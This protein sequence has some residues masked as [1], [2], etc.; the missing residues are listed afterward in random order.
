MRPRKP[1]RIV[2]GSDYFDLAKFPRVLRPR[3]MAEIFGV[4]VKTIEKRVRLGV[5]PI[6]RLASETK[7]L[8][9]AKGDVVKFFEARTFEPLE[10]AS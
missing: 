10:R 8:A 2:R 7:C 5:F 4:S 1:A 3:H 9:F 6:P